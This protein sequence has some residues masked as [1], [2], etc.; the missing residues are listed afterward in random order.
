MDPGAVLLALLG[1]A[2]LASRRAVFQQYDSTVGADTVAAGPRR[3][4]PPGQGH[5][6]GARRNDRREPGRGRAGSMA[7]CGAVRRRGDAQR[8]D[9]RGPA[10]RRHELPELR[11]PDP[12]GG[13]L[14]AQRGRARP[15]R[16]LPGARPAGDRRQRVAL[17]RVAGGRHCADARDRRSRAARRR[18][19]RW[20]GR[21]SP[22]TATRRAGRR[23]RC[24]GS[25][26]RPTRCWPGRRSRTACRS[27]TSARE[28]ALQA[29]IREAIARGLVASAQD[30]SGGGL[31]VALA[32]GAMW[33][34]SGRA[35]GSP[36]AHSPAV[37]LFGESPSRLV[38]TAG[39]AIR[40]G[41]GTAGPAAW[42]AGRGARV[43]RRRSAR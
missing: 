13:V 43:G 11:R 38:V 28:A 8:V 27:S 31:A 10:P 17:Q 23:G 9:H 40:A 6:Q 24:P 42:A 16:R 7:G 18:R 25:R 37:D 33:G 26:A 29:F 21:R 30:V 3:R 12:A 20:S 32:E 34:E 35:S 15:R 19:R 14:A 39:P 36:V 4:R 1:S 41:T 22:R 5:D 2:N